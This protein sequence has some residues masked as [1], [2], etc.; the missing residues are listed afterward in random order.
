M[1]GRKGGR[2]ERE[3]G[4]EWERE[5]R[6]GK[7]QERKAKEKKDCRENNTAIQLITRHHKNKVQHPLQL[8]LYCHVDATNNAISFAPDSRG[9]PCSLDQV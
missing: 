4:R 2:R 5:G 8:P 7:G 1:K 6:N 9:Y 3:E